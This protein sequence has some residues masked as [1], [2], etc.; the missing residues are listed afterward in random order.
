[1]RNISRLIL[2]IMICGNVQVNS[3]NVE[4]C[5]IKRQG[6]IDMLHTDMQGKCTREWHYKR[7]MQQL[8]LDPPTHHFTVIQQWTWFYLHLHTV[9]LNYDLSEGTW[10]RVGKIKFS[11]HFT[12]YETNLAIN[13]LHFTYVTFIISTWISSQVKVE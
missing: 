12:E 5:H 3:I 13:A 10:T 2:R 6:S 11:F 7:Y 9:N 8:L 1:M 4:L